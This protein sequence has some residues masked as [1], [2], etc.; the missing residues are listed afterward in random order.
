M[1]LSKLQITFYILHFVFVHYVCTFCLS[2]FIFLILLTTLYLCTL[3]SASISQVSKLHFTFYTL[4]LCTMYALFVSALSTYVHILFLILLATFYI[5]SMHVYV[6]AHCVCSFCSK[7]YKIFG[8][9]ILCGGL[10]PEI[11]SFSPSHQKIATQVGR[12]IKR[13][14]SSYNFFCL[15]S[16]L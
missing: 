3:C 14:S 13:T 4:C 16:T 8:I 9:F 5:V 2:K 1:C 7:F 10:S 6:C 11:S 15:T 12:N